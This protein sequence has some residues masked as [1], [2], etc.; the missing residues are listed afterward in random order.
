MKTF[1][2]SDSKCKQELNSMI[3][4]K[5]KVGNV[6]KRSVKYVVIEAVGEYNFGG[7]SVDLSGISD[8]NVTP[9]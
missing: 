2:V 3:W 5:G 9:K 8:R 6:S 7:T 1:I 4:S